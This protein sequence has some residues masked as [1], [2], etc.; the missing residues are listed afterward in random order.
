M[1]WYPLLIIV[2]IVLFLFELY[3]LKKIKHSLSTLFPS[4]GLKV[5]KVLKIILLVTINLYPLL[6]LTA[7]TYTNI[8]GNRIPTPANVLFDYLILYPFWISLLLLLQ[9]VIYYFI[10]DIIKL[11]ILPVFKKY[12]EKLLSFQAKLVFL[13][14]VFFTLYIPARII[15]D[16]NV[17]STRI[18]EYKKKDLPK[19]LENFR[20][21]FISDMQADRYTD[22]SRLQHFI[23]DVNATKPDLVLMGGDM[24][25]STPEYIEESGEFVGKIKSK[26]GVYSC[27]GDHDNWAYRNNTKRSL[28]EVMASLKKHGVQMIDD[29]KKR[30]VV[31]NDSICITFI[32]NTYV[33]TVSKSILDSLTQNSDDCALKIFLTHQP[34]QFLVDKAI[35]KNYDLFLAGHTHGGQITLLFPFLQLSP[36]RLETKYQRGDFHFGNMLMIVTRGLGMSLAPIRYNST[37]EV[38]LIVLENKK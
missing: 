1:R 37:P 31:G 2:L 26:L 10:I 29:G 33:E 19:P 24:I 11:L 21:T 35:Q 8:T 22:Q 38:T 16:Y 15:F 36:T 4:K 7:W 13:L 3:F 5:Y 20:L 17:I 12:K 14:L 18:V 6:L 34:R 30:I 28:K 32:T 23:N 9:N 27:V 25:T